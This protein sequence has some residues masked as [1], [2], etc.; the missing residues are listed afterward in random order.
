MNSS[1][2]RLVIYRLAVPMK[3]RSALNV[4]YQY[5][6]DSV[7]FIQSNMDRL[8]LC[9]RCRHCRT[10][11]ANRNGIARAVPFLLKNQRDV[12]GK[13]FETILAVYVDSVS[14]F[15]FYFFAWTA[16]FSVTLVRQIKFSLSVNQTWSITLSIL[17]EEFRAC[18][19]PSETLYIYFFISR[20]ENGFR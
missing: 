20:L 15:V 16:R 14:S 11:L 4:K 5:N 17:L 13:N 9:W 18:S 19:P 6:H 8:I 2:H 1:I 12:S 7:G 10:S 3:M